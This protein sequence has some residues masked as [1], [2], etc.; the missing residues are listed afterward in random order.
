MVQIMQEFGARLKKIR[1]A[2]NLSQEAFGAKLDMSRAAI[3]AAEAGKNGFSQDTLYKLL[4]IFNI[5]QKIELKNI[6]GILV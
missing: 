4:D 1:C 3:A 5:N 6:G 2:L